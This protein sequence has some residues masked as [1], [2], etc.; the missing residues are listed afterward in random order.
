MKDTRDTRESARFVNAKREKTIRESNKVLDKQ[1]SAT[2]SQ[3][4]RSQKRHGGSADAAKVRSD[5]EELQRDRE[6]SRRMVDEGGPVP[7]P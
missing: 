6:A 2:D 7:Q 5:T 1:R 4:T 3:E